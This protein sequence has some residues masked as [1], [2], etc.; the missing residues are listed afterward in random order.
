[1]TSR[2]SSRT[3]LRCARWPR[4]AVRTL[5]VQEQH[6]HLLEVA[7][8]VLALALDPSSAALVDEEGQH[9]QVSE[10][11]RTSLPDEVVLEAV[12]RCGGRWTSD[13]S[14]APAI[15][16]QSSSAKCVSRDRRRCT[17]CSSVCSRCFTTSGNP[18]E[19][20]DDE[21]QVH[22]W[23]RPARPRPPPASDARGAHRSAFAAA[24]PGN[25]G[26]T[27]R[28]GMHQHRAPSISQQFAMTRRTRC[29]RTE[30]DVRP[31]HLQPR[32]VAGSSRHSRYRTARAR[33]RT[34]LLR[35]AS[36]HRSR[37]TVELT[38]S[39]SDG[40]LPCP[41]ARTSRSSPARSCLPQQPL[42]SLVSSQRHC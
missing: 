18:A 30:S 20:G 2:S 5:V 37:I 40:R 1:M 12:A 11:A 4:V 36:T 6:P 42:G 16:R 17:P 23:T 34:R 28:F 10:I 8:H 33:C 22:Q 35:L 27:S 29:R 9:H 41:Q 7:K 26:K 24:R 31:P 21:A 32:T 25:R 14:A 19:S 39:R 15:R 3:G 13:R 38:D